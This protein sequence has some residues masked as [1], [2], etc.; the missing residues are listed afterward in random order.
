MSCVKQLRI[1]AT[2]L[3]LVAGAQIYACD[4]LDPCV[5]SLTGGTTQS[6]GCDQPQGDNCLCCC[7][8]ILPVAPVHL[9]A[10][11]TVVEGVPAEAVACA[12][13]LPCPI[14]HPPQL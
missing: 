12:E 2:L 13:A 7:N 8:H 6:D 10:P 11:D 14:E 9:T 5:S 3:L 4:S 1:V